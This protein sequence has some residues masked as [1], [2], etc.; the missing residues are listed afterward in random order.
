MSGTGELAPDENISCDHCGYVAA[1][2]I[3]GRR[4]CP[5]CLAQCGAGCADQADEQ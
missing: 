5:H 4:L 3:A 1:T 2:E